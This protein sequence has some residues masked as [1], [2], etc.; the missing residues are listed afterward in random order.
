MREKDIEMALVREVRKRDGLALK[1][2]SPGIDGVPDRIAL[3]KHGKI[4]FIELKAPGE[5]MRP[6]QE[7]RKSQLEEL[8][9]LVFC[10]DSIEKIQ[11]VLDA[12]QST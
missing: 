11:E 12:I 4:G 10:V 2:I 7:K 9:F 3:M 1:F 8:G 5:K 6:L